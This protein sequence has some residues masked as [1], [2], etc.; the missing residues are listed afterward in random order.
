[1][2]IS[3]VGALTPG[4]AYFPCRCSN[5]GVCLFFLFSY[6]FHYLRVDISHLSREVFGCGWL[7]LFVFGCGLVVAV[8]CLVVAG[9]GCLCLVVVGCVVV[10]G[11]GCLWLVECLGG[12]DWLW[13]VVGVLVG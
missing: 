5:P 8:C 9:C 13:L 3:L 6:C 11:C 1:V 2:L 7:W 4:C 10:V 12:C